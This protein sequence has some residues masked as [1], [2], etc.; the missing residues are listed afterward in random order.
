MAK[1]IDV[2]EE[3]TT[4]STRHRKAPRAE[5]V[6][7]LVERDGTKCMFPGC[8][9][10]LDFSVTKGPNEVTLDHWIPQWF[11][12]DEGWSWDEIWAVSNLK[13][14]H[15]KCNA[16]K[17]ERVPNE[18]GTLPERV[19]REFRYRRQKRAT[20]P[21]LCHVCDNGRKLGPNEVCASCSSG[22]QPERFPR[23]AKAKSTECDHELFW[24]WACSIGIVERAGATEMIILNG[25]GGE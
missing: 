11:G 6:A 9:S 13:L 5:L 10:E 18:D 21:E 12:K 15:K 7:A 19:T 17:G 16:K 2:I 23:W 22:P 24:C 25:E 8:G 4:E 14:M 20:R 1:T 3:E